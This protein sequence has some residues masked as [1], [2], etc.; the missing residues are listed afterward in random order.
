MTD[1][2]Q[3]VSHSGPASLGIIVEGNTWE[4]WDDLRFSWLPAAA[5]QADSHVEAI[6]AAQDAYTIAFG[7]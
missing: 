7:R 4:V 5:G 1:E 3:F 6:K 2:K